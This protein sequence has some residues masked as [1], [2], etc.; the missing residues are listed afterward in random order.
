MTKEPPRDSNPPKWTEEGRAAYLA[1][2]IPEPFAVTCRWC[3]EQKFLIFNET[4]DR[5][6]EYRACQCDH[7]N[8]VLFR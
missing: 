1:R 6:S 2:P 7:P 4:L 5:Y 3:G 8:G